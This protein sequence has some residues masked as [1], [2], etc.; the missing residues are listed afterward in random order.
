MRIRN[1]IILILIPVMLSAICIISFVFALFFNGYLKDRESAQ[2]TLAKNRITS[3]VNEKNNTYLGIVNDWGHWNDTYNFLNEETSYFPD[4]N[5]TKD[6]FINLNINFMIF[7]KNDGTIFYERYYDFEGNAFRKFDQAFLVDIDKLAETINLSQDTSAFYELGDQYYFIATTD[8]TDSTMEKSANGTLIIG[9]QFEN[10]MVKNIEEIADAKLVSISSLK[11]FEKLSEEQPNVQYI[12][13]ESKND[14]LRFI[15]DIP[16]QYDSQNPT[17]LTFA[18]PRDVYFS[19]MQQFNNFLFW[20]VLVMVIIVLIVFIT[21]SIYLSNPF[22]RLIKEVRNINL[23]DRQIERLHFKG[24]GEFAFLR[25]SINNLLNRIEIEQCKVKNNEEKLYATLISVG[26]GVIV[27]DKDNRIQFMNPVA[28]ELTGWSQRDALGQ[29]FETVFVIYNE[30]TREAVKSPVKE[31]F[32]TESIVQLSNHTLLLSKDGREISIEDTAAPI[33]DKDDR[34]VG[35]VIVFRDFSEKKEK[36]KKIEYLS[37]HDQLT[38][39]NNRRYFEE[40]LQRMDTDKNLP[41]SFIYADVNGL[42]TINDAFGHSTGDQ[43]IQQVANNLVSACRT[44]DIIARTGGDEFIMLLPKTD[45][46]S[47]KELANKIKEQLAKEKIMGIDM[48]LSFG[49]DSKNTADQSVWEVLKNA[50]DSMYKK[51]I[52][53]NSG[54]QNAVIQSILHTL[55]LVHPSEKEHSQRVGLLCEEIGK[56]YGLNQK[57]IKNLRFA[58]ELHDIGKIAIEDSL[59]KKAEPLSQSEWAQIRN[60]PETGY[61]ILSTSKE[62]YKIAE[63]ILAHHERWDGKGYPKGLKE[64]NIPWEARAIAVANAYDAM[65][66]NLSFHY[67]INQR[68][69]HYRD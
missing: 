17:V 59:L 19:G 63:Y 53:L 25:D 69:S 47:A 37:Y 30:F 5:L 65:T 45:S 57:E 21:L 41:I 51:K 27:I 11:N 23:S 6:T 60:H 32:K 3:W 34:V 68:G 54:Q 46:A 36:Q 29:E 58:G 40:A 26:D 22:V 18:F 2:V 67:G 7:L 15:Y 13:G 42:K 48:S 49:W 10:D 16:N 33:K 44:N 62:Y 50:E 1:K 12:S 8:I 31:V 28:Q 14:T 61:R 55:H 66:S 64:E 35:C 24:K 4:I 9:R 39:L 43:L 52:V 20:N 56:V 38:G